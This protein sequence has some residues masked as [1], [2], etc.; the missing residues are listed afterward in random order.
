MTHQQII[1]LAIA[2]ASLGFSIVAFS[3]AIVAL[4]AVG[5]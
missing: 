1:V 2:L 4:V 5:A 3:I